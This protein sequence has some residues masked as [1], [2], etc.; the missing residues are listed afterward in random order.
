MFR[1]LLPFWIISG[2]AWRSDCTNEE[3]ERKKADFYNWSTAPLLI[4]MFFL[5]PFLLRG[6]TGVLM[7][8]HYQADK[9]CSQSAHMSCP[10]FSSRR[11]A[12]N[13]SRSVPTQKRYTRFLS[14]AL[15]RFPL[16][17]K[18]FINTPFW[19]WKKRSIVKTNRLYMILVK[20]INQILSC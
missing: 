15:I 18:M 5:A 14:L 2:F 11:T 13:R 4:Q 7:P 20:L 19:I 8:H 9:K 3:N 12:T 16:Y 10:M 17:F 1:F 6:D